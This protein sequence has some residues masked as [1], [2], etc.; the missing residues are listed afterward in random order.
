[1]TRLIAEV[2]E[3]GKIAGVGEEVEG[4][5]LV[6]RMVVEHVPDI[7]GPDE[8]RASGDDDA[9]RAMPPDVQTAPR[10][11]RVRPPGAEHNRPPRR[12]MAKRN[13]GGG[14]L[15][16]VLSAGRRAGGGYLARKAAMVVGTINSGS[17]PA[18]SATA[19]ASA[20]RVA[21]PALTR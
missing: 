13:S 12:T 15:A 1:M 6:R 16:S 17:N 19:W 9:H 3:I 10:R 4:N 7:G 18:A 8:S 14:Q 21:R 20:K 5:D 2:I 11:N